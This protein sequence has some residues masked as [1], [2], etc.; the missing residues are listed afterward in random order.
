MNF[1]YIS[2]DEEEI[3]MKTEVSE[4]ELSDIGDLR[5]EL[6][7]FQQVYFNSTNIIV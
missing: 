7:R 2:S 3:Y 5:S 4:E 1:E 6:D